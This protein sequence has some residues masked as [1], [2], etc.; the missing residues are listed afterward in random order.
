M[1]QLELFG[2]SAILSFIEA[3]ENKTPSCLPKNKPQRIPRGT[4][5]IS[6]F[7]VTPLSETPAFAKANTGII[8]NKTYGEIKCSNLIKSDFSFF[9]SFLCGIVRAKITP[10]IVACIPD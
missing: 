2:I 5:F 6:E 7:T 1:S 4:G 8:P 9:L 10:A 3:Y